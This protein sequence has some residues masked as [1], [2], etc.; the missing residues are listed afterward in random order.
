MDLSPNLTRG[1]IAGPG[2]WGSYAIVRMDVGIG[3]ASL[4][5]RDEIA[6]W[7]SCKWAD[8]ICRC[9]CPFSQHAIGSA[10]A[11]RNRAKQ[12]CHD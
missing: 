9:D 7:F 1:H 11:G 8:E 3:I 12:E 5:R 10:T 4:N 6:E 2:V